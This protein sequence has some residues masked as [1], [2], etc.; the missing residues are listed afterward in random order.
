MGNIGERELSVKRDFCNIGNGIRIIGGRLI[1]V[2]RR[3]IL[4]I[5]IGGNVEI[6]F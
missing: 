3:K 1:L 6:Y 4:F 2:K 5:V